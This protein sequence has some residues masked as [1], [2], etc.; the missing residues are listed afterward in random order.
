M[1]MFKLKTLSGCVLVALLVSACNSGDSSSPAASGGSNVAPNGVIET[2][3]GT[4]ASCA[5]ASTLGCF[6][7][8]FEEPMVYR[9]DAANDANPDAQGVPSADKCLYDPVTERLRCKPAAGTISLLPNGDFLYFNALEGTEDFETGILT[10]FGTKAINDQTRVMRIP[11]GSN[12]ATAWTRPRDVGSGANPNGYPITELIPG[13]TNKNT[14]GADGALFCADVAMLGDGRIMAVGGTAYYNEPGID[15]LPVG[16]IELE[17]LKTSRAYNPN[18]NSWA[19]LADMNFGRWYPSVVTLADNRLFVASGVTKLLKPVYPQAP[20]Q[21]GRNVVVT[22]TFTPPALGSTDKGV[23]KA[24]GPAA[25]RTLPLYPRLHLLPNGHVYYNAGG[26]SFNPFGQSIDQPLWNI[27]ATYNPG[28]DS[29]SDLAYAGLPFS[30]SDAGLES[31]TKLF[32]YTAPSEIAK[33]LQGLL[34]PNVL[35]KSPAALQAAAT[36]LNASNPTAVVQKVLGSGMRGSTF[37]IMMPLRPD[38]DGK[39]RDASFLTAGGVLALVAAGSPGS[40]VAVSSSR[41]DTVKTQPAATAKEGKVVDYNSEITGSLNEPRWYGT[42]VLLPDDSVMVFSGADRDGV[43]A[44]GVEMA[45][46]TA[47]RFDPVTKTWTRM[48]TA[49]KPRTYHNTALL[50]PDGR[51]LVGGHA[52]ISTLY[53]KNVNLAALGLG[54]NDGRDPSFEIYSPPYMSSAGRPVLASLGGGESVADVPGFSQI[55]LFRPGQT[56]SVN[57]ASM[58]GGTLDSITLVR[59]TVMTHLIDADQRTVVIPA[60]AVNVGDGSLNFRIPDQMAIL[61]DGAYMVFVRVKDAQGKLLPSASRSFMLR[62]S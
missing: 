29:W 52:P 37:S 12:A 45:R 47:E 10:D 6:T 18:N 2:V 49:N 42:G 30:F 57:M 24:N 15:A 11:Q 20:E 33:S 53:F 25:Q 35:M 3:T 50:M 48:A 5:D 17:G 60:Q 39:Y 58:G 19:Q 13:L 41:I 34:S 62:K 14:N 22:E 46:R 28:T 21:S 27:A 4:G 7:S 61:P 44:P 38:A 31:F 56:M 23:W 55:P 16:L 8:P 59:H 54:P 51:V 43:V 36:K 40:Y 32:N 9:R 1:S 26:Q